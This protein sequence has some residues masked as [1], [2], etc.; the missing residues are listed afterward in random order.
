MTRRFV[1]LLAVCLL[2][3]GCVWPAP[4]P[5]EPVPTI[6]ASSVW[7]AAQGTLTIDA[8]V[9][10]MNPTVVRLF[11]ESLGSDWVEVDETAPFTFTLDA[12]QLDP[13]EHNMVVGASDGER[14]VVEIEPVIVNGCNGHHELCERS[15]DEARYATT[16]NAMSSAADGWTGPNQNLDVLAQLEAGVRA[17]MLDT[18]R[19]GDLNGIG[20]PQVPGVDPDTP[21][22]CHAFCALG[23]QPLVEGLAEIRSFI[24]DNPGAV[25]TLIIESYL[26][27][28][29]TAGAFD[30]AGLAPYAYVR[31]GGAW[32]TLGEMIDAGTRLV[33]LQDV[34]VDP[35]YPWLMNVWEHS[36]ETHF[37][38]SVPSDFSCVDNRGVPTNDLFI[39][40]HFLTNV[41]GSPDLADQ[42]NHN[43]L[44]LDRIGECEDFH[45]TLA[46]FVTVDFIDIGDTLATVAVLNGV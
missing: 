35:T 15:F 25:V 22:L 12:T 7:H 40:N 38:N 30:A 31:S 39:L 43:P 3:A 10:D 34:A 41:F 28:D 21:Y 29:L 11:P 42:V 14:V 17:L 20:N 32:P 27:H 18:Y 26:D 19:A 4:K 6:D 44:L 1:P 5:G 36:F 45:S 37:S 23:S 13:G 33:V 2:A 9:T 8:T 24:D 46:N 16:H